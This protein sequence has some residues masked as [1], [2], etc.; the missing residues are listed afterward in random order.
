MPV[1]S[2]SYMADAAL[3][4]GRAWGYHLTN[5]AFHAA[6]AALLYV[7]IVEL[8]AKGRPRTADRAAAAF[9][10]LFFALHPLRVESVAWIA[11]RR[12]VLCGFFSLWTLLCWVRA[13]RAEAA[14]AA[15]LRAGAL[16]AFLLALLSKSAA[17]PLP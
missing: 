14:R 9:G 7:L 15:R 1:A 2:L 16:A 4:G 3:W 12:D 10:A 5:V 8:L 17:M 13:A 6:N 11:E